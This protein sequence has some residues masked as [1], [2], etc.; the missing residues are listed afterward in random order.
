MKYTTI[1]GDMWDSIAY[2]LYGDVNRVDVLIAANPQ[3]R[4]IYIFSA[5]IE[6]EIPDIEEN[7]TPSGLPPWKISDG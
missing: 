2:K 4:K 5:G 6:L 7:T 3:H 1:Q